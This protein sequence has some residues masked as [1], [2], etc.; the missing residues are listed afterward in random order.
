LFKKKGDYASFSNALDTYYTIKDSLTNINRYRAIMEIETKMRVHDK[1][2]RIKQLDQENK[3]RE[4]ELRRTRIFYGMFIGI[5]ILIISLL[6]VVLR[7]RT[8]RSRQQVLLQKNKFE[9]REKEHRIE[10]MQGAIDAEENERHKIADQLHDETGS[11]LALAS[12]NIS[13]ALERMQ[14]DEQSKEK[15]GKAFEFVTGVS[16]AIRDISHRLTPLVIKKYGFKKAIKDMA[17][18]INLS[19]K[20]KVETIIIGFEEDDKYPV[21]LLNN[22]YRIIQELVHNILKHAKAANAMIE[23]VE[24]EKHISVMVEDDGI[25]IDNYA[26][27]KGKGLDS[28]QSKIAYLNG[29][30]EIEKKKDKGTLIVIE[31]NV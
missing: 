27:S 22:L 18:S 4:A 26:L 25:G 1:E 6:A 21:V 9:Q 12:L 23:V 5:A 11:M 3:T 17:D 30:M 15:V 28:I 10:V 20:L 19:G 24:H 14:E 13:S 16:A 8:L 29:K 7:N 2:N 31:I